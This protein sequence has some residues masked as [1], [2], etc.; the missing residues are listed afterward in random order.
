ML[1]ILI[2][3]YDCPAIITA[4]AG[5]AWG[6][7]RARENASISVKIACWSSWLPM[8]ASLRCAAPHAA[9]TT[10]R[11]R[12]I[13]TFMSEPWQEAAR[14]RHFEDTAQVIDAWRI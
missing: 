7:L 8:G 5:K 12:A 10:G 2:G 3:Q 6:V 9:T 13:Q 1:M 14:L 11:I 4:A